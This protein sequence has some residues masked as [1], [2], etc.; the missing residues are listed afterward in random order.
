MNK[1]DIL[2]LRP[3]PGASHTAAH[4]KEMGLQAHKLPL[5]EVRP[6]PWQCPDPDDFDA[7][8]LSSAN[9]IRHGGEGVA[10]LRTLPVYA[11]G[12]TTAAVARDAGFSVAG[13]GSGGIEGLSPLLARD[14]RT[15]LLRLVGRDHRPFAPEGASVETIG[16]YA[17]EPLAA[18]SDGLPRNAIAL[19]YSVR[20]A[21]AF[22][23][24]V[25]RCGADRAGLALVAISPTVLGAAGDRWAAT[26]CA[27]TPDEASL[28]SALENMLEARA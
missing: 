21:E 14:G 26:A 15:R 11:V 23:A 10:R 12:G 13:V 16:V 8:L 2:I 6:T 9:A 3:E 17:A 19:L 20:S 1:P 27:T 7:L 22:S 24:L 25:D 28:L 5:F 18:R 4:I